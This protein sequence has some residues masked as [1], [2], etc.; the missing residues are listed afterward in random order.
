VEYLI[1]CVYLTDLVTEPF[2]PDKD[3]NL[4]IPTKLGLGF[5]LNRDILQRYGK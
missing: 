2:Q 5:E 1:P 4:P 3:G